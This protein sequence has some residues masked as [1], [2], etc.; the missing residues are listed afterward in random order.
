[1]ELVFVTPSLRGQYL[2]SETSPSYIIHEAFLTSFPPII[3]L[4]TPTLKKE[5]E[6][7]AQKGVIDCCTNLMTILES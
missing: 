5:S 6:T 1:M 3:I 7:H 2:M 4:L